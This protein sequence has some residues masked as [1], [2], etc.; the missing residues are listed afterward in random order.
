[1]AIGE[2]LDVLST[3]SGP[4]SLV[5]HCSRAWTTPVEFASSRDPSFVNACRTKKSPKAQPSQALM[6]F[7]NVGKYG[8][9]KFDRDAEL[10]KATGELERLQRPG[11]K[12]K[13]LLAMK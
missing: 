2:G 7:E 11:R 5:P 13:K 4:A 10:A 6:P 3:N 12:W 8:L 1:M 9:D